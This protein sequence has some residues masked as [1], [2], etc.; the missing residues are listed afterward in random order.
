MNW[1]LNWTWTVYSWSELQFDFDSWIETREADTDT[2]NFFP[3]TLSKSWVRQVRSQDSKHWATEQPNVESNKG[4]ERSSL[5][6]I[7]PRTPDANTQP[8]I[9]RVAGHIDFLYITLCVEP[10]DRQHWIHGRHNARHREPDAT[11]TQAT[12]GLL[13]SVSIQ[14]PKCSD[15]QISNLTSPSPSQIKSQISKVKTQTQILKIENWNDAPHHR[16]WTKLESPKP[17]PTK[18]PVSCKP[19]I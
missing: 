2:L 16:S 5:L 6:Y 15:S 14:F 18:S 7:G 11:Q 9:E 12:Q 10:C 17:K 19:Q 1:K 4:I 3:L 13:L 8:L